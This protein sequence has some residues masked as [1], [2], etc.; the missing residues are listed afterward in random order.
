MEMP[1]RPAG[2]WIGPRRR[3]R[4]ERRKHEIARAESPVGD[5]QYPARPAP[6]RPED[7]VDV[8]TPGAPSAMTAPAKVTLDA[9]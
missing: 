3:N 9:F 8:D 4:A 1:D 5:L 7:D 2:M 6:A